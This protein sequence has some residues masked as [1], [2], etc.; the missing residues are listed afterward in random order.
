MTGE[1]AQHPVVTPSGH[2]YEKQIIEK[3]LSSMGTDPRTD[4]LLSADQLVEL[5]T[6]GASL[7]PRVPDSLTSVPT[8]LQTLQGEWDATMLEVFSLRKQLAET[9]QQLSHAL[10]Q[11]DAAVRVVARLTAERDEANEALAAAQ[12]MEE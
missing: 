9:R 4:E 10:Y 1:I 12:K 11:Y 6:S 8:I 7:P 5:V 2:V 3:H